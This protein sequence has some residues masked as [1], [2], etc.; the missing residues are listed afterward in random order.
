MIVSVRTHFSL[1][2]VCVVCLSDHSL[3]IG[4]F[5]VVQKIGHPGLWTKGFWSRDLDGQC[6]G[7]RVKAAAAHIEEIRI[8]LKGA[9]YLSHIQNLQTYH[10]SCE[11]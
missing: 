3:A 6:L 5:I 8:A 4:L 7:K 9:T 1:G 2:V 11:D 10:N